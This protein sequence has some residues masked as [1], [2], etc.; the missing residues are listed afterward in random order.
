M[1]YKEEIRKNNANSE[2][3]HLNQCQL[4][5]KIAHKMRNG[6]M[7]KCARAKGK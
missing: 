1:L 7:N 4:L 3:N 6:N 5:T 2:D